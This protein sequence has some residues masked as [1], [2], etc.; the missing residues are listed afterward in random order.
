MRIA[1]LAVTV[2][3]LITTAVIRQPGLVQTSD[4]YPGLR[5]ALP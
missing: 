3:F 1:I 4:L 2:L 5:Q